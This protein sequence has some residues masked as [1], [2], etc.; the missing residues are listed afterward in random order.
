LNKK[1]LNVL[2]T[3]ELIVF[4]FTD[5]MGF[6]KQLRAGVT[7]VDHIPRLGIGKIDRKYFKQLVSNEIIRNN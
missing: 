4:L 3:D 7:F 1:I 6:I 5:T 2:R